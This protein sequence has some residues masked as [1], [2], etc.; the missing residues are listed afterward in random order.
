MKIRKRFGLTD[1]EKNYNHAYD[2]KKE[3][4]ERLVAATYKS[5]R[6]LDENGNFL[7]GSIDLYFKGIVRDWEWGRNHYYA[8]WDDI[9]IDDIDFSECDFMR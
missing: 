6:K 2:L 9:D 3:L 4:V 8:I 5:A 7:G 1:E